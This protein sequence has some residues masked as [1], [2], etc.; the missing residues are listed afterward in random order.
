MVP[1]CLCA[2]R[3]VGDSGNTEEEGPVKP[4]RSILPSLLSYLFAPLLFPP[5][6][7]LSL[8]SLNRGSSLVI[9]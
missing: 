5:S 3:P 2:G 6:S 9:C 1:G 8:P 7:F 4:P